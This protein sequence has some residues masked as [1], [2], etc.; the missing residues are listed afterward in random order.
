MRRTAIVTG[1]T[2][3]LGYAIAERLLRDG[4]R[5]VLHARDERKASAALALLR[6]TANV[7]ND[8]IKSVV[9]DIDSSA[10]RAALAAEL[11]SDGIQVDILV[12]CAGGGGAHETW[13]ETSDEKWEACF[14]L[15]VMGTVGLCKAFVPDM[16]QRGWGRVINV[17]SVA[18][19]RPLAIGPEYASAKAAVRSLTVS[20]AQACANSGVTVNAISPGL[21]MTDKVRGFLEPHLKAS[22]SPD[23]SLD[24]FA[25]R[26][27]F[28]NLV[29]EL[30]RPE[31]VGELASLLASDRGGRITGQ[32]LVVDGGYL[33][34]SPR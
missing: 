15:N 5:I 22:A 21:C 1:A 19:T 8:A 34:I 14:R 4:H 3:D 6:E 28:P 9:A 7:D 33:S 18:G 23:E 25:S 12:N 26:N 32:D 29:G 10:G 11:S 2:G 20:L 30:T 13:W 31:D 27:V 17:A 16:Q 24:V